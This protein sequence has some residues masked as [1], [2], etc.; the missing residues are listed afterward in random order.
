MRRS[1]LSKT[2]MHKVYVCEGLV[3][4]KRGVG[5]A[6]VLISIFT[7]ELG[8]VRASARSARV[9]HS[10]LRYGLEPLTRARFSFVRGKN[11][12][13]LTGVEAA[14]RTLVAGS[15]ARARQAGKVAKL[16]L[17]LIHGEEVAPELY[18]SVTEGLGALVRAPGEREAESVESVL[19]LKVLYHLGYL[20][21]TPEL[22]GFIDADFFSSQL[23]GEVEASRARLLKAINESLQATGL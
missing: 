2:S 3:L 5:E 8:L 16:L 6:N 14:T 1:L 23:A 20:P 15:P 21:H 18:T 4:T 19:V 17:R 10:K 13:R 11:E 7:R 22:T 9:E 12:W